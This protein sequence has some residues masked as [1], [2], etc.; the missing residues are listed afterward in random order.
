M[1]GPR[2]LARCRDV[3]LLVSGHL[4]HFR[5]VA[6]S[7]LRNIVEKLDADVFIQTAP[8]SE[9]AIFDLDSL[10]DELLVNLGK[11]KTLL[12][13]SAELFPTLDSEELFKQVLGDRLKLFSHDAANHSTIV[14]QLVNRASQLLFEGIDVAAISKLSPPMHIFYYDAATGFASKIRGALDR[15]FRMHLLTGAFLQQEQQCDRQYKT[16][17]YLR[18]DNIFFTSLSGFDFST[19][20]ASTQVR[21]A[22]VVFLSDPDDGAYTTQPDFFFGSR[23]LMLEICSH[24]VWSYGENIWRQPLP[25]EWADARDSKKTWS[26][27]SAAQEAQFTMFVQRKMGRHLRSFGKT[28]H[29]SLLR[30]T[31][32]FRLDRD[33]RG[34]SATSS[35]LYLK[36]ICTSPPACR[37]PSIHMPYAV[38]INEPKQGSFVF[39]DKFLI[40]WTMVHDQDHCSPKSVLVVCA[41]PQGHLSPPNT[42]HQRFLEGESVDAK[43]WDEEFFTEGAVLSLGAEVGVPRDFHFFGN[44]RCHKADSNSTGDSDKE[45]NNVMTSQY[46]ARLRRNH[47]LLVGGQYLATVVVLLPV[48]EVSQPEIA[49]AVV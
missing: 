8:S 30:S 26:R 24:L 44:S 3:A 38:W 18:W 14:S 43:Q 27:Y 36:T 40:K 49:F 45:H 17:G 20:L 9:H 6:P 10:P 1:L 15:F 7:I 32:Q 28:C 5:L 39:A 41:N 29:Q 13:N 48:I 12:P 23:A 35:M 21:N 4:R 19:S 37:C 33:T 11:E 16:V 31:N 22:E 34:V 2:P 47:P 42:C 25:S 46:F